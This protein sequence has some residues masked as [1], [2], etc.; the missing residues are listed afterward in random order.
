MAITEGR[1]QQIN[2]RYDAVPRLTAEA[3]PPRRARTAQAYVWAVA[4]IG[5][6]W[7]FLWAFLDKLFG[8]GFATPAERAWVNGG[9]P[10]TGFLKGTADKALGDAFGTL[11]GQ[12]WVDW[13]FMMGLLG[14][15]AAL[16]L[17]AG[18]R[19]AAATGGLLM[20]FMWAA[21]L[22]LATNPFMDE[23]LVYA[24]VL[25]GLALAGAGDA[26]GIGGWWGR[27]AIVRRF[28]ILK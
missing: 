28:P 18:M 20:V 10:T 21:E 14:I 24:V 8:W 9:S 23:H 5:L 15:G 13:L 7:V 26:L 6:G 19:I 22:P 17:G 27:T 12:A 25:A 3:A 16:I 4:R 11:A 2:A 1:R